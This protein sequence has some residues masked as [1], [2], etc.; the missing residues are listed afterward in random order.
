MQL[1]HTKNPRAVIPCCKNKGQ[2]LVFDKHKP[3]S[4]PPNIRRIGFLESAKCIALMPLAKCAQLYGLEDISKPAKKIVE[5]TEE[6]KRVRPVIGRI[7]EVVSWAGIGFGLAQAGAWL[8]EKF[9]PIGSTLSDIFGYTLGC[10]HPSAIAISLRKIFK[11]KNS[12]AGVS[13]YLEAS[14]V[15]YTP[16]AP[17]FFATLGSITNCSANGVVG[18]GRGISAAI[19]ASISTFVVWSAAFTCWWVRVVRKESGEGFWK[20]FKEFMGGFISSRKFGEDQK[21][22]T[23]S[24]HEA[25]EMIGT[26]FM[27]WALPWYALRA[28]VAAYVGSKLLEPASFTK[29]LMMIMCTLEGLDVL[30]SGIETTIVEKILK[31]NAKPITQQPTPGPEKK[32]NGEKENGKEMKKAA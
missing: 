11:V 6:F 16:A 5:K 15:G 14:V 28:G 9:R 13:R 18:I 3:E 10:A 7:A 8:S 22:S 19:A 23:T 29:Q 25:G 4:D 26:S 17:V 21:S 30:L 31:R 2:S 1:Q 24:F 32:E 27:V 20:N 12:S